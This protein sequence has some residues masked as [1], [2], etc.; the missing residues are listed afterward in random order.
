MK[1][2]FEEGR[3]PHRAVEPMMMMMMDTEISDNPRL[4]GKMHS[5][6]VRNRPAA[7]TLEAEEEE[8]EEKGAVQNLES[9]KPSI[10]QLEK[11]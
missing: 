3:G 4:D 7:Y 10:R 8:E 2:A 1:E 9:P 5:V 11:E 6:E